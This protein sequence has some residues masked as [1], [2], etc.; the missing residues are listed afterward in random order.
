M[1]VIIDK[2]VQYKLEA[3]F[4]LCLMVLMGGLYLGQISF[5]AIP[6]LLVA[7]LILLRNFEWAYYCYFL[8]VPFSVEVE[9]PGGLAT[10]LPTEPF[11]WFL[12]GVGT[13]LFIHRLDKISFSKYQSPI[14]LI[15]L[16][17]L[18][19][20]GIS[21][22]FSTHTLISFKW[23]LAKLWYIIPFYFGAFHFLYN[24]EQ[25]IK[26]LKFTFW[27]LMV[28][29]LW[30]LKRHYGY[31]FSFDTSNIVVYPI[32]RNHV[33]YASAVVLFLPFV[34][35]LYTSSRQSFYK[36]IYALCFII[37]VIAVYYSYTRI[38]ILCL[39]I[40]LITYFIIRYRLIK[41]A[42]IGA[43]IL[44]F[45]IVSFFVTENRYVNFAPDFEK[46]ITHTDFD[47]LLDATYKLEDISTMERVYRWVAGGHMIKEKPLFGFGP[48]TF[49]SNYQDYTIRIFE[50]YVS[51]N[52]DQSGVHSYYLMTAIEQGIIGFII[53]IALIF[54]ILQTGEKV[55]NNCKNP[56]TKNSI[57]AS[58]I[59]IVIILVINLINDT[60]E[61]DKIGPFFFTSMTIISIEYVRQREKI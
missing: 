24:N 25:F 3:L 27:P 43:F 37:L 32:F 33:N 22:L 54:T 8:L 58:I 36:W 17:H 14:T 41:W 12:T 13:L 16:L 55:Y 59:C 56:D 44:F 4:L 11:M 28:A 40:G 26:V 35:L 51:D 6:I 29:V 57:V 53:F 34:W 15:L 48:G 49:Y 7:A 50:T 45:A 39:P 18:L 19:W 23:F 47:N 30:V 61:V 2:M 42:M 31:D 9:L 10:D 20:I 1:Y 21:I 5:F 60:L 46:T 52:P 38:A